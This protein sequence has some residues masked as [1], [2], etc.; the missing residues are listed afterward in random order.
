MLIDFGIPAAFLFFTDFTKYGLFLLH[1]S[2][3][4][5]MLKKAM[6][7]RIKVPIGELEPLNKYKISRMQAAGEI[8]KKV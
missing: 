6:L 2:P 4:L 3:K 5:E 1:K 7:S 8:F